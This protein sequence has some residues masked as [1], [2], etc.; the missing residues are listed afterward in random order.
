MNEAKPAFAEETRSSGGVGLSIYKRYFVAGGGW[1]SFSI[2]VFNCLFTQVL[3]SASDYWLNLWTNS[4]QVKSAN[5]TFTIEST[6]RNENISSNHSWQEEIT[7][8][9]GSTSTPF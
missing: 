1:I 9:L 2:L 5:V 4:E 7:L 8:I 3:F 6:F